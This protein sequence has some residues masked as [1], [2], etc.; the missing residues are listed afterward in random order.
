MWGF[1]YTGNKGYPFKGTV[2]MTTDPWLI[3]H[4]FDENATVNTFELEF[5]SA[6]GG[7]TGVD[8]S[9]VAVDVNASTNTNRRIEW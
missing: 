6:T 4:R 8:R 2:N 9:N 7:W 5:N 1:T 3:Y